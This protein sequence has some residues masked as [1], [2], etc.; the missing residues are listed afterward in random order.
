[1]L[2]VKIWV[3]NSSQRLI[4]CM[5]HLRYWSENFRQWGSA[6]GNSPGHISKNF[7]WPLASL[8]LFLLPAHLKI[9][10]LH[11]STLDCHD[12]YA[13]VSVA[14]KPWTQLLETLSLYKTS[15]K[16]FC[17]VFC[18]RAEEKSLS[19]DFWGPHGVSTWKTRLDVCICGSLRIPESKKWSLGTLHIWYKTTFLFWS[20]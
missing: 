4:Y 3:R 7:P 11:Y 5:L 15:L 1:M 13:Q 14:K 9:K 2:G 6:E 19:F 17:W 10:I 18:Y 8:H 12:C 20:R 16:L